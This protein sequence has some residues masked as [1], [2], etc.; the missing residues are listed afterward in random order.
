[1]ILNLSVPLKITRNW[2]Y[3]LSTTFTIYAVLLPL[4]V[5]TY[6]KFYLTLIPE[7]L[8]DI[9]FVFN[10]QLNDADIV[11][12]AGPID[13]L[14]QR[15][16]HGK[17]DDLLEYEVGINFALVCNN[18]DLDAVKV[19]YE[20]S[21]LKQKAIVDS[22]KHSMIFACDTSSTY[23][24]NNLFVPVNLKDYL[25]PILVNRDRINYVEVDSYITNGKTLNSIDLLSFSFT[26]TRMLDGLQD[27]DK[28]FVRFTAHYSG[29]RWYMIKYYWACFIIGTLVF[30]AISSIMCV[31]TSF[32]LLWSSN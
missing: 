28:S 21:L 4:S 19:P 14:K 23:Y 9:P 32:A 26:I 17:F 31:I 30:W 3:L 22:F 1:M 6:S 18:Q 29:F 24:K 13:I 15:K 5:L 8:P 7:T 2:V 11:H 27:D 16:L 20:I 12:N 10:Q 25:P